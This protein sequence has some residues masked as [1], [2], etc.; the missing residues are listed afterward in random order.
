M[1]PS[2]DLRLKVTTALSLKYP[3]GI[4]MNISI[5]GRVS[6]GDGVVAALS[7]FLGS[8]EVADVGLG[9]TVGVPV[10]SAAD[11]SVKRDVLLCRIMKDMSI[12]T[13]NLHTLL[14]VFFFS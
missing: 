12:I 3:S 9:L 14:M 2:F 7:S 10:G 4:S 5:S 11:T 8:D 6:V 1:E 13:A